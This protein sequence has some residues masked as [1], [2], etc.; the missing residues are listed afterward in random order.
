MMAHRLYYLLCSFSFVIRVIDLLSVEFQLESM[1]FLDHRCP[2][3]GVM[4]LA[5]L[6]NDCNLYRLV[7]STKTKIKHSTKTTT[8]FLTS[9]LSF[10]VG[11][12]ENRNTNFIYLRKKTTVDTHIFLKIHRF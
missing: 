5:I 7:I 1:S 12:T 2:M 4:S 9:L 10:S 6:E 3:L 8:I 11:T